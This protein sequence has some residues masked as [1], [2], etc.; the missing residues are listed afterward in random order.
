GLAGFFAVAGT[1]GLCYQG[2]SGGLGWAG[3]AVSLLARNSFLALFPAALFYAALKAGID[4]TL[5]SSTL[6]FEASFLIQA[7]ILIIAAVRFRPCPS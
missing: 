1:Y 2:F 6:G 4:Q 5:L 7:L 3:I